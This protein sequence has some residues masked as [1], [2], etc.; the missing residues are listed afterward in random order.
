MATATTVE[1]IK[2]LVAASFEKID[3]VKDIHVPRRP[4]R[5]GSYKV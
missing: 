2:E 5:S 4:K 1:E 3:E